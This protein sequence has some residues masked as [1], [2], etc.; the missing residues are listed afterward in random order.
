[1]WECQEFCPRC[2]TLRT[3]RISVSR[4]SE[5]G[6]NDQTKIMATR[7]FHCDTCLAFVRSEEIAEE[8]AS[9]DKD[10]SKTAN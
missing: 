1:M 3:M 2:Q 4:R 6:V 7:S 8:T 5:T 9:E 10:E